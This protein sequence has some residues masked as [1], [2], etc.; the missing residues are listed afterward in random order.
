MLTLHKP[1]D[2]KGAHKSQDKD[3]F[4][5]GAVGDSQEVNNSRE[6]QRVLQSQTSQN[7]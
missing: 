1:A 4:R 3:T 6:Q 7:T 5:V 2:A